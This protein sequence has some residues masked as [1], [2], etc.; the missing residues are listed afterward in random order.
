[1]KI[2]QLTDLH[3]FNDK[4]KKLLNI[5]TYHSVEKIIDH[6]YQYEKDYEAIIV[7]GDISQDE[8]VASY[9]LAINLLKQ[10]NKPIYYLQGNHDKKENLDLVFSKQKPIEELYSPYWNFISVDTVD[11]GK[12]SG[13]ISNDEL[14]KLKNKISKNEKN[15]IALIMHHHCLKLGTPLIDDC[16]LLNSNKLL[17][18]I[19]KEK[20]IKLVIC[21]HAHNDYKLIHK[22]FILEVAPAVCFQWKKGTK[23]PI[24]EN[25]YGYKKYSFMENQ[26]LSEAILI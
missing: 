7:T 15:N 12:D 18:I 9:Q 23:T 11:Y 25:H 16:M 3:L 4:T 17:E 14:N 1:M 26:Y 8:T 22:N 21:G 5:I 10:L 13:L 2:I 19:D 24:T 6:I 20:R